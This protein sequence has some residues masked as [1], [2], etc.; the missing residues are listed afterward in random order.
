MLKLFQ[1]GFRP[2]FALQH[3]RII[4]F[5]TAGWLVGARC[6]EANPSFIGLELMT[7]HGGP[8]PIV[9]HYDP[10]ALHTVNLTQFSISDWRM[11]Q[12]Q[13]NPL[14]PTRSVVWF[15]TENHQCWTLIVLLVR[16]VDACTMAVFAEVNWS[17]S[18]RHGLNSLLVLTPLPWLEVWKRHSW[19]LVKIDWQVNTMHSWHCGRQGMTDRTFDQLLAAAWRCCC[20]LAI[21]WYQQW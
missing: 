8:P 6:L 11:G 10:H 20:W 5:A 4:V 2:F 21:I 16:V 9:W 15:C 3:L 13:I 7:V 1:T 14:I 19:D 17:C 12:W 18:F